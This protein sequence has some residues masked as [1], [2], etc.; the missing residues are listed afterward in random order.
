VGSNRTSLR[1]GAVA[2]LALGGCAVAGCGGDGGDST[3]TS[4]AKRTVAPEPPAPKRPIASEI[5][6]FTHALAARKCEAYQPFVF[7]IIRN[8]PPGA[9]ATAVE[10]RTRNSAFDRYRFSVARQYGTAA[11]MEGPPRGPVRQQALWALDRDG[12]YRFTEEAGAAPPQIGS[13]FTKR[14]EAGRVAA[15]YLRGVRAR[16]C[17]V[18]EP[19][20]SPRS[21]LVIDTGSPRAACRAILGGRYL[22]PALRGSPEARASVLGGTTNLAFVGIPTR[23]AYF[24][25]LLTDSGTKDLR[26]LD[27]LPGPPS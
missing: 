24:T 19:L 27:V 1:T 20:L 26:V 9:P 11:V 15:R 23:A 14:A 13:R 22:A 12:R 10:C 17:A 3:P 21:R 7:S 18:I 8:R 4:E 16:N 25:M 5:D 6:G 2:L